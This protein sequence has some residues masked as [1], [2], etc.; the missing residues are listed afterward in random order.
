MLLPKVRWCKALQPYLEDALGLSACLYSPRRVLLPHRAVRI[1][2]SCWGTLWAYVPI[3]TRPDESWT[4]RSQV[5]VV[6]TTL[7][8][9]LTRVAI[10]LVPSLLRRVERTSIGVALGF[11]VKD[12]IDSRATVTNTSHHS[13]LVGAHDGSKR[14]QHS[15]L[16]RLEV[17]GYYIIPPRNCQPS[18]EISFE[19]SM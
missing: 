4:S 10:V 6:R 5:T 13:V 11:Q 16:C 9:E 12:G 1:S 7:R 14:I 3:Y 15:F 2:I 18:A 8:N 19:V 17:R